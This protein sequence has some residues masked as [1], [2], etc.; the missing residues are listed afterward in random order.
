MMHS[1]ANPRRVEAGRLNRRKRGPLTPAGRERLRQAIHRVQPWREATGPR[2]P[3]GKQRAAQNGKRRQLGTLS[4]RQVRAELAQ[5]SHLLQDS[6]ELR[7]LATS[8]TRLAV[9][10]AP[11]LAPTQPRE[12]LV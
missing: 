10:L 9:A 11:S 5:I 12:D 3:A 7:K 4:T 1:P 2:T 8:T 6:C